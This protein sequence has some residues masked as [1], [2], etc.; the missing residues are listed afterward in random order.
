[1]SAQDSFVSAIKLHIKTQQLR[2]RLT[3]RRKL[4]PPRDITPPP[5]NEPISESKMRS[6]VRRIDRSFAK[7]AKPSSFWREVDPSQVRPKSDSHFP[8]CQC[9]EICDDSPDSRQHARRNI[10]HPDKNPYE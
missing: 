6:L 4:I 5:A 10:I 7:Q 8:S 9:L 1:M 2:K 3:Q